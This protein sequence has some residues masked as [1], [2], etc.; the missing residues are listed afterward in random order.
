MAETRRRVEHIIESNLVIKKG[1]EWGIVN[2]R[3]LARYIEKNEGVDSTQDSILGVI[4]RYPVSGRKPGDARHIFAGCELSL[5]NK[6]AE[7]QVQ[8]HEETM[9]QV[10]EFASNLKTARGENVKL[11]V[12]EGVIRIMAD[13]SALDAFSKTLRPR[14][15][16]H[17]SRGLTEI[18]VHL[19]PA[20]HTTKGV[21]A[22]AT[23]ELALNDINLAGIVD[24]RAEL[25]LVV[26]EADAPRAL[27]ALQRILEED[28]SRPKQS[29]EPPEIVL[30]PRDS[31]G[32][33]AVINHP[34]GELSYAPRETATTQEAPR[35]SHP[36]R[37]R[38]SYDD[39]S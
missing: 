9:Y 35:T 31:L 11:T 10:A 29:A 32:Q 18:T 20:A 36:N 34:N 38:R 33:F 5:R 39:T 14:A 8:Y 4:R 30:D 24:T 2:T 3:A 19:P 28:T 37:H 13:Q 27:E 17:Y 6:I 23:M 25:S 15:I 1:L 16:T 12:G 26:A 22:K 21:V 7:L